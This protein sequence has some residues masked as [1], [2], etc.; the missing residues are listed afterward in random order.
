PRVGERSGGGAAVD[1]VA[2]P[3]P[4]FASIQRANLDRPEGR[5][6]VEGTKP[7]AAASQGGVG[8]LQG[9]DSVEVHP[10]LAAD[11]IPLEANVVPL[12]VHEAR[13]GGAVVDADA[14]G[15]VDEED[16]VVWRSGLVGEVRVV[17]ACGRLI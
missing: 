6:I 3:P 4:G 14:V 9:Q 1:A 11:R 12:V 17:E 15:V 8:G 2:P 16:A 10:D 13:H 5:G 7:D